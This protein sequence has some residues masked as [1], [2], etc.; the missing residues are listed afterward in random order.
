MKYVTAP[1]IAHFI[2]A[3]GATAIFRSIAFATLMSLLLAP[4]H[5]QQYPSRPIKLVV[6]YAAGGAADFTARI[7]AEK[8]Q[9][10]L[11][12]PVI[13]ENKLVAFEQLVAQTVF[14][15]RPDGYTL[16]FG[17]TG[18]FTMGSGIRLNIPYDVRIC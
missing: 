16:C 8:L 18:A 13:V 6:G 11:N 14:S 2:A 3:R 15:A 9:E 12:T 4:A 10:V 17:M 1:F 7:F 5:A